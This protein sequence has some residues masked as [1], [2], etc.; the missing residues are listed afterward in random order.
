MMFPI[1]PLS[2][3]TSIIV[4]A[5]A[6]A[7]G[8]HRAMAAQIGIVSLIEVAEAAHAQLRGD[9]ASNLELAHGPLELLHE[10]LIAI[11]LSDE[12]KDLKETL[13]FVQLTLLLLKGLLLD[14][15][16]ADCLTQLLELPLRKLPKVWPN[17]CWTLDHPNVATLSAE[18]D[19]CILFMDTKSEVFSSEPWIWLYACLEALQIAA[20]N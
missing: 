9:S 16:C 14:Q 20:S 7:C 1:V 5:E 19:A 10:V 15:D 17:R 18:V 6:Q 8:Q 13:A 11:K 2:F 3:L 12:Y 4:S